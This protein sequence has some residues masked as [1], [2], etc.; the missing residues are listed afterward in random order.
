MKIFFLV[1]IL[2]LIIIPVSVA[3]KIN[4]AGYQILPFGERGQFKML[5]DRRHRPQSVFL[6]NKVHIVF[7]AGNE[8]GV[9]ATSETK[10][11]IVTYDP[12]TGEFSDIVT[13][14]P[15]P[16]HWDHHFGPVI[17]ADTND[18]L[19]VLFGGEGRGRGSVHLIS[20]K[21]GN[22]GN[23]RDDWNV[24]PQ[25][26]PPPASYTSFYRISGN[27]QLMYYRTGGH[28][29]SWT[30]LI[31]DDNGK[32]WVGP[33]NDVTDLDIN[34][35]IEW[36]S[37][38]SI[39]PGKDGR[40]LHVVFIAYDDNHPR[41]RDTFER[42]RWAYNPRYKKEVWWKYNLYY[43]KIDLQTYDVLNFKGE[44]MTTP[45][46]FDQA[47]EKCLI[48][49]TEWRATGVPPDIIIDENG[50]PAFLHIISED[51]I[52][53]NNYYFVRL[54]NGEWKKTVVAPTNHQWS[55]GHIYLDEKTNVYHAYLI[56][57]DSYVDSDEWMERHGGGRI[58][59]WISADKGNTWE[60]LRDITPDP[61]EYEG[62]K[63]NNVQPVTNPDGSV[64][65]GMLLFYGWKDKNKAE[66]RA[67][68]WIKRI[69]Q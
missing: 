51:E 23:S 30:Y 20:K 55:G 34:S 29:S 62:W 21:P 60:K 53:T 14:T 58:E 41:N 33:E 35:D 4:K 36:S 25:I 50:N 31:S 2:F 32:T 9:G 42:A 65:E 3:Q 46:D 17:R 69:G 56:V 37:Y 22:I 10:P 49:D 64:V 24:A 43:V 66:A 19:G 52:E 61:V 28:A 26:A 40:Y 45:I 1:V 13:L 18:H 48:W 63:F 44:K 39:L 15:G 54:V 59:E 47:N 67:F 57:G 5:N 68:L 16:G 27:R 7:N 8:K 12:V 11:M 38:H 6:N